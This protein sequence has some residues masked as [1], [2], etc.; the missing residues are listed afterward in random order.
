MPQIFSWLVC[1]SE[2]K[3][4]RAAAEQTKSTTNQSNK[5]CLPSFVVSASSSSRT[6]PRT[7]FGRT[8]GSFPVG[9]NSEQKWP[10]K[11]DTGVV[12][13]WSSNGWFKVRLD[14]HGAIVNVRA[15]PCVA[16]AMAKANPVQVPMFDRWADDGSF[17]AA[18]VLGYS[19]AAAAPVYRVLSPNSSVPR[20]EVDVR[21]L[22]GFSM[23]DGY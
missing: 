18:V 23:S 3:L 10:I 15:G 17:A 20:V 21:T 1:T 8:L 12:S 13:T 19:E 14:R 7:P 4:K 9:P 6:S 16:S 11:G 2:K 22:P 5:Q